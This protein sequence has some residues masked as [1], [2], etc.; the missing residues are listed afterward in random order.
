VRQTLILAGLS[1]LVLNLASFGTGT[2]PSRPDTSR[3][4]LISLGHEYGDLQQW[5]H[6][7]AA[8]TDTLESENPEQ[9]RA[10]ALQL[11]KVIGPLEEDFEK[12]TA[13]LSTSQLDQVLPL[14]ERMVFAHAGFLILQ[15]QAA[16]LG[17]DPTMDPSEV[18][19][20]ATELSAVLDFAAE[21][22]RRILAELTTP[23]P[24]PIR[25]L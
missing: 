21:I 1:T 14:W 24:T 19:D 9:A 23:F 4:A 6:A 18:H 10:L 3:A 16:S 12:T 2:I 7:V 11:A 8:A 17:A 5:A 22:Q 20:L 25:L 13:A 15:E